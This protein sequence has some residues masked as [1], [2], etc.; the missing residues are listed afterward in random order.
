MSRRSMERTEFLPVRMR[1]GEVYPVAYQGSAH[2]NALG[3]ADGLI[4]LEPGTALLEKG[5]E[6]DV[7]P[8]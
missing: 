7:R 1:G 3:A 2:L 5:T 6:V 8:F 4:C